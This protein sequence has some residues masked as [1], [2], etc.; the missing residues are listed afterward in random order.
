MK[1]QAFSLAMLALP[2][3]CL[4]QADDLQTLAGF[5]AESSHMSNGSPDWRSET[6]RVARKS[7]PR[8][9]R[10]LGLTQTRRFGLDD[11]QIGGLYVTPLSGQATLSLGGRISPSHRV[12]ARHELEATL[13]YEFAPA[14]LAHAGLGNRRYNT[15]NINSASLALEHYFSSFSLS[16]AWRPVR[17]LGVNASSTELRGTY[18]YGNANSIGLIASSGQ[19]A[20][21]VNATTVLLVDVRSTA[22]LGRHSLSRQ[23]ALSYA[24]SRTWQGGFY[25]QDSVHLG[26]EYTF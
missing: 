13:Q 8:D 7:G 22:L 10:E 18:Y 6:L 21:T 25:R 15:A 11:R 12:L 16:A 4:A 23:W 2:A 1:I 5:S 3:V 26:A 17:A 20:S 14:W 19:E 24:L 9:V